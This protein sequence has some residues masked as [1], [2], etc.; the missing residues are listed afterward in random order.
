LLPGSSLHVDDGYVDDGYVD[1][2]SVSM[3]KA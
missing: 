3:A 1:E 2:P